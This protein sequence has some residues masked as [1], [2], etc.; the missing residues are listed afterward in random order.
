MFQNYVN[1]REKV[2]II[3]THELTYGR[4]WMNDLNMCKIHLITRAPRCRDLRAWEQSVSNEVISTPRRHNRLCA[5]CD[6]IHL[7]RQ[8]CNISISMAFSFHILLGSS[9]SMDWEVC[10]T[11]LHMTSSGNRSL[12]LDLESNALSTRPHVPMFMKTV[13][14]FMALS[15]FIPT[16]KFNTIHISTFYICYILLKYRQTRLFFILFFFIMHLFYIVWREGRL[17]APVGLE[18]AY[19]RMW[20]ARSTT[21]LRTPTFWWMPCWRMYIVTFSWIYNW[22]KFMCN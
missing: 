7:T 17:S 6:V 12:D 1:I 19:T 11:R 3:E 9:G 2:V 20:V 16:T 8:R 18:P 10:V 15:M 21:V 4:N 13:K 5:W 14:V 22:T